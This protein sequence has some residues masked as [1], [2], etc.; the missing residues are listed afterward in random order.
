MCRYF[1]CFFKN[2]LSSDGH[3]FR[4]LQGQIEVDAQTAEQAL[5]SGARRFAALRGVS[6]WT[7]GADAI[8]VSPADAR[9]ELDVDRAA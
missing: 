4:C 1:V 5:E 8:E 9:P 7:L 3:P 6:D 2:L